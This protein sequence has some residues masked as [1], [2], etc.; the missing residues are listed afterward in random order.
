MSVKSGTG[1]RNWGGVG[2]EALARL[3][4]EFKRLS[5]DVASGVV[6]DPFSLPE[7]GP[8]SAEVRSVKFP[9]AEWGNPTIPKLSIRPIEATGA[10]RR[11]RACAAKPRGLGRGSYLPF[12]GLTDRALTLA[13][14]F[15]SM[16]STPHSV[17]ARHQSR[18]THH[19]VSVLRKGLN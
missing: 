5:S 1:K 8:V 3:R 16:N 14:P 11:A 12:D 4:L 15:S 19:I 10:A 17:Y 18:R 2:T 9:S 13:P 7:D 6:F